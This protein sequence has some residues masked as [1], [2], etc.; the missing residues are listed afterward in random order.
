MYSPVSQPGENFIVLNKTKD[1]TNIEEVKVNKLKKLNLNKYFIPLILI[2]LN[3]KNA[4]AISK[5]IS[6]PLFPHKM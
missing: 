6:S 4:K 5:G 2:S 3:M 1:K